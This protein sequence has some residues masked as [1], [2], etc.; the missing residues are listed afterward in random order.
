MD[1]AFWLQLAVTVF[2][3]A[4]GI[5]YQRRQV[6]LM[7]PAVTA[8]VKPNWW[9]RYWPIALMLVLAGSSWIPYMTRPNDL[10][11]WPDEPNKF[12][13]KF[14]HSPGQ[15]EIAV[16]GER[17][18]KYRDGF[19]L[20]SGCFAYDGIG[21]VLD[22]PQLQTSK[23][24]DIRKSP[25][26]MRLEWGPGFAGYLKQVHAVGINHALLLVPNGVDTGQFSTLRQARS[27]GVKIMS[28]GTSGGLSQ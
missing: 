25:I 7:T 22:T 2:I 21:D 17:F 6:R 13:L 5:Y 14:A 16:N 28:A 10:P 18:W 11:E 1:F 4:L 15:C 12:I 20:A 19:R 3:G 26:E 9:W 24:Y 8:T 23:M 27:M